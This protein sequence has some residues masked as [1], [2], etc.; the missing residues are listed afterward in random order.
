MKELDELVRNLSSFAT[1]LHRQPALDLLHDDDYTITGRHTI[2][3]EETSVMPNW[4]D[5]T[6]SSKLMRKAGIASCIESNLQLQSILHKQHATLAQLDGE[7]KQLLRCVKNP[8]ICD[9]DLIKMQTGRVLEEAIQFV[10]HAMPFLE[11]LK[12]LQGTLNTPPQ[13]FARSQANKTFKSQKN[14]VFKKF[15][16]LFAQVIKRNL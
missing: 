8:F 2:S 11:E 3:S 6:D 9:G 14:N 5:Q 13:I 1:Q 16:S 12:V 7:L 10:E 15:E 4:E